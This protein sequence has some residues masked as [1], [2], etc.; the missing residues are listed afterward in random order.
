[1]GNSAPV[2][3]DDGTVPEGDDLDEAEMTSIM[4]AEQR[5]ELQRAA[6]TQK[7][8][9]RETARPPPEA[10]LAA[11][12]EAEVVIPKAAALPTDMSHEPA[13][14][15]ASAPARPASRDPAPS[16]TWAVLAFVLLAAAIAFEM[17]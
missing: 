1:M 14:E 15:P 8:P 7:E 9:E 6:R 17:R 11:E 12:A 3:P 10:A 13:P 4:D 5:R 2:P 16:T